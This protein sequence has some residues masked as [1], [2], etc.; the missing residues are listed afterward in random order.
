[1]EGEII[2]VNKEK[3]RYK[4][5]LLDS[6]NPKADWYRVEDITSCTREIEDEK[7]KKACYGKKFDY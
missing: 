7:K 5:N 1:M 4:V 3:R 6:G 2:E